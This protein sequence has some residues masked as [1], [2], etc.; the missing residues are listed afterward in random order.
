MPVSDS[1]RIR[2]EQLLLRNLN[3]SGEGAPSTEDKLRMLAV[4]RASW[5]AAAEQLDR[6]LVRNTEKLADAL[7]H[8]QATVEK[9]QELFEQLAAPPWRVGV[10]L[11]P[12]ETSR[13]LRVLVDYQGARVVVGLME[14]VSVADLALGDE[15]YLNNDLTAVTARCETDVLKVGET[16]VFERR[17]PDGRLVLRSRD[18]ELVVDRAGCLEIDQLKPG[19]HVR[20]DRRT[21]IAFERLE[22]TAGRRFLIEDVPEV[23]VEQVG[24]QHRALRRLLSALTVRLV[25]PKRASAYGLSG[26]QA[27]LLAGPPGCG[28]T[29]MARVATGQVQ[30]HSGR[31]AKFAVVK[32]AE[33]EEPWVG[34]TQQNIRNCF[35]MLREAAADGFAVLFLDEIESV[36]RHRGSVVGHHSDKFLAALLAEIDGFEGRTDVAIIAATNRK[37]LCDAALISRFDVEITVPRPDM[38]GAREIFEIHLPESR[39]FS[40]N[41]DCAGDTRRQI[42][43]QAVSRLYSP[44]GENEVCEVRFRDNSRRTV[45]AGELMSGRA[46]EQICREACQTAFLREM[47]GGE[48]GV[49]CRDIDAAV[50]STLDR[51]STTLT[52]YNAHAYLSDLPQDLDVV[53]VEPLRTR[54][55]HAHRYLR[56]N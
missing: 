46:I 29:L 8:S 5:P 45:R 28:K 2:A 7:R 34:V 43:E 33:W 49:C 17:L 48:A 1:L 51:F 27:I 20:F 24:G 30:H 54:T 36:G 19:D 10:F 35:R 25:N 3:A 56:S 44:N 52:R 55:R 32:P 13:G 16:A 9:Y 14:D 26:R 41:G 40:P 18:E 31:A 6:L 11:C 53:A 12:V 15:V 42:I 4:H 50:A 23:G 39:P 37:D 47:E 22:Q 21:W 38:S